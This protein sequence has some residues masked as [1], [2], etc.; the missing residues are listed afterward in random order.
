MTN[1]TYLGWG[2]TDSNGVAK[3]NHD[4]NDD[5][6][7]H[8]YT[9]S[10]V[11]EVDVVASL[12]DPDSIS[13][14]SL[15][16][17]PYTVVDA[18]FVDLATTGQKSNYWRNNSGWTVGTPT[19]NG[20]KLTELSN[21]SEYMPS[22]T[23]NATSWNSRKLFDVGFAVEF[24]ISDIVNYPRFRIY[25]NSTS[26]DKVFESSA[27]GHYK[28]LVTTNGITVS[29]DNGSPTSLTSDTISGQC[30]LGFVDTA[31]SST[32]ELVYKNFVVYPI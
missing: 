1:Y 9:G 15:V 29:K 30:S 11:G 12:D 3:L 23:E 25:Y 13:D 14:S 4:A 26:V 6:L 8:S 27:N 21:N 31:T 22:T 17:E 24:D 20:T 18:T 16:S 32:S 2:T 10:G 7:S 19:D 28:F 5:P